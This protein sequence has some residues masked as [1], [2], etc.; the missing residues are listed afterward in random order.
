MVGS[1]LRATMNKCSKAK[2]MIPALPK[3]HTNLQVSKGLPIFLN[4]L[5]D[6]ANY[7]LFRHIFHKLIKSSNIFTKYMIKH[8]KHTPVC[9]NI[10]QNVYWYHRIL[11][12]ERNAWG[13]S[14]PPLQW[15]AHTGTESV[16]LV[17]W[18][19]CSNQLCCN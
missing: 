3:I 12:V 8:I 17:L 13:S 14:S 18:A 16:T 1:Y 7:L 4:T 10:Q 19:P 5:C 6:F 15:M 2:Q 11:W 9:L